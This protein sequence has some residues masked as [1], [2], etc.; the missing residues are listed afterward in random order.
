M[1][2]VNGLLDEVRAR[3]VVTR[4][5]AARRRGSLGVLAHFYRLVR[6][7]RAS[8]TGVVE[9]AAPLPPD[10]S[11]SVEAGVLRTYGPGID[12]SF[13]ENAALIGGMRVKVGS[14]VYDGSVRA[15][16]AKLE[17]RF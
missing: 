4:L 11:G 8:H 7:D 2:V 6:L 12:L 14:D 1:C 17:E 10:V 16:L 13:A 5:A 3:T 15:A 9:S